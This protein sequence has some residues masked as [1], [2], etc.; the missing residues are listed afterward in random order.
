MLRLLGT[1]FRLAPLLLGAWFGAHHGEG[2]AVAIVAAIA[3]A[4]IA[5]GA[6]LLHTATPGRIT[7]RIVLASWLMPWGRMFGGTSLA[8]IATAAFVVA[9]VQACVGA[10]VRSEPWLLAAWFVD[11]IALRWLAFS[12]SSCRG[13]R[14]LRRVIGRVM[15]M[16]VA[17]ALLGFA[18]RL[19]GFP[20]LGAAIA[21]GP[22]LAIGAAYGLFVS[23]WVVAGSRSH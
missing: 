20:L 14:L 4:G 9:I 3:A 15:A 22:P 6:A 1:A 2:V 23:F 10:F 17:V 8:G 5:L 13:D 16:L 7:W 12:A 18:A 11:G 21:G 19:A